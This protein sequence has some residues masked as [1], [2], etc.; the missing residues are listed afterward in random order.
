MKVT[1]LSARR[2][3]CQV[4]MIE[5]RVQTLSVLCQ[6]HCTVEWKFVL[7]TRCLTCH[8][9]T[10]T[11]ESSAVEPCS[12]FL[13]YSDKQVIR[14]LRRSIAAE[15]QK[16]RPFRILT[17]AQ[18]L[19]RWPRSVAQLEKTV[20]GQFSGKIRRVRTSAVM[21]Q[22]MPHASIRLYFLSQKLCVYSFN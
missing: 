19:L 6:Q 21:N 5:V 10:H 12:R 22:I 4:D 20:A 17:R 1:T 13:R 14:P 15:K 2:S 8:S 11:T 9:L 3:Q 7:I 18:L 16:L